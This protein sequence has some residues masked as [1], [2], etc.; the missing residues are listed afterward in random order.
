[1]PRTARD[2]RKPVM[3]PELDLVVCSTRPSTP[4]ND[5]C[6]RALLSEDL[7]WNE[8]LACAHQHKIGPLLQERLRAL[9][10]HFVEPEQVK[11]LDELARD[12]GKNNLGNMG[13]MIWLCG[14]F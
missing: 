11:R 13:E 14:L 5:D 9:G 7:D 10:V 8:V 12:L 2:E 3:R 4:E 6:L 1:M